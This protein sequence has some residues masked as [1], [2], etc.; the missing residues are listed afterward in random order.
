ME[1]IPRIW[2]V[3]VHVQK[4]EISVCNGAT[5]VLISEDVKKTTGL[6]CAR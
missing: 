4:S 5:I 6:T 3:G 2:R 1:D